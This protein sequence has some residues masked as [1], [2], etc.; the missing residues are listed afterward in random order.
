[1]DLVSLFTLQVSPLEL[2]VR[3]SVTYWFLFLVL[4]FVMR[5]DV[6]IVSTADVLLLV[7]VADASQSAMAGE[8]KSIADGL[9]VVTTLFAWNW[10]LDIASFHLPLVARL[11]D[12]PP[13]LLILDGKIRHRNLRRE[14]ITLDELTS[15]M[16]QA[17][18]ERADQ[19]HRAYME[20]DGQF[21]FVKRDAKGSPPPRRMLP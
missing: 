1:M 20:P 18:I 10:L 14:H 3:G 8:A 17:G 21:S 13:L 9:L 11:T 6:G 19:V 5:R 15:Q 16:R 2:I 4:R 7:L 12:P